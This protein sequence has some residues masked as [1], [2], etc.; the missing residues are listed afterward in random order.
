MNFRLREFLLCFIVSFLVGCSANSVSQQPA[1]NST[2][3][4]STQGQS[5]WRLGYRAAGDLYLL[6]RQPVSQATCEEIKRTITSKDPQ[7]G[8]VLF[9]DWTDQIA[10]RLGYVID[11]RRWVIV[12]GRSGIRTISLRQPAAVVLFDQNGCLYEASRGPLNSSMPIETVDAPT[13]ENL[14]IAFEEGNVA[15]SLQRAS[16]SVPERDH[17]PV[18]DAN[19]LPNNFLAIKQEQKFGEISPAGSIVYGNSI[20]LQIG[21]KKTTVWVLNYGPPDLSNGNHGWGIFRAT[22]QE[23]IPLFLETAT[24]LGKKHRAQAVLAT[25]LDADGSDEL[26][27]HAQYYEGAAYKVFSLTDSNATQI[28]SSFYL[29]F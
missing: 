28:Y 26:V 17:V 8:S 6:E 1:E 3:S 16:T 5:K 24:E 7:Y 14:V 4:A 21:S 27:I 25:D 23:L 22:E 2:P 10:S 19:R 9:L 29:G 20:D 12:D 18:E 11:Q 15:P 13:S